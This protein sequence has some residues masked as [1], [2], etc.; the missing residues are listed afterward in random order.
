ML[1]AHSEALLDPAQRLQPHSIES[2]LAK[3]DLE[4][5]REALLD[6]LRPPA[7]LG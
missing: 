1:S 5:G 7:A 4:L 6:T 3:S 2:I